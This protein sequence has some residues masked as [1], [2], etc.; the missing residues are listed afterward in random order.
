MKTIPTMYVK[1]VWSYNPTKYKFISM[2]TAML[3]YQE[4]LAYFDKGWKQKDA[5]KTFYNWLVSEI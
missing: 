1:K 3:N 2:E 5:P 4:Y